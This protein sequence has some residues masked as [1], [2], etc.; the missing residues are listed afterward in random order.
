MATSFVDSSRLVPDSCSLLLIV[1][2]GLE[3]KNIIR[4]WSCLLA[5][6]LRKT[7]VKYD[8]L[9]GHQWGTLKNTCNI[10]QDINT[11]QS[12]YGISINTIV[13]SILNNVAQY[14]K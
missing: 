1:C 10:K 5:I 14:T 2:R 13:F 9:G 7:M 3:K 12:M 6:K 11:I 4:I 8:G